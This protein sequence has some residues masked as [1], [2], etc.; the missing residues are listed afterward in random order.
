MCIPQK[1]AAYMLAS[2]NTDPPLLYYRQEFFEIKKKLLEKYAVKGEIAIQRIRYECWDCEE[3]EMLDSGDCS[4]CGNTGIYLEVWV[5]LQSYS[6]KGHDFYIPIPGKRELVYPGKRDEVLG[7][8][9]VDWPELPIK[10]EG[11]LKKTPD[12]FSNECKLWLFALYR[13][14]SF[15]YFF[16]GRCHEKAIG[17]LST[18]QR[19]WFYRPRILNNLREFAGHLENFIS[20]ENNNDEMPF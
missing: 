5:Q 19:A 2:A 7:L 11:T 3:G 16:K 8:A 4:R 17:P 18:L 12:I 20:S 9:P 14:A 1:L 15:W 13:P 6:W 10:H